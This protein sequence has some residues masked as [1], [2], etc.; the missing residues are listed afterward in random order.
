MFAK[1]SNYTSKMKTF[2]PW[3][4]KEK[5]GKGLVPISRNISSVQ[6]VTVKLWFNRP[7]FIIDILL[8]FLT[9]F[10]FLLSWFYFC[11]SNSSLFSKDKM[12]VSKVFQGDINC[13]KCQTSAMFSKQLSLGY[14]IASKFNV[15][16]GCG[17]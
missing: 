5:K 4:L 9:L 1:K 12:F 17:K 7:W 14:H 11:Q 10:C 6:D 16:Q 8:G 15:E 3:T 13:R 2:S